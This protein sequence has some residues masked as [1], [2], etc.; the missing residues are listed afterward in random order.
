MPRFL[1]WFSILLVACE[2]PQQE[3]EAGHQDEDQFAMNIRTAEPNTPEQQQ[4]AFQLPDGFRIELFASEPDIGKPMNISFDA[5]GRLWVTQSQEYPFYDSTRAGADRI[6]ILE[7]TDRDGKADKFV[8]FA[9]SLNIPIGIVPV[10]DGAIAF[11]IPYVYHLEDLN[12]DDRVDRR[13]VLLRGFQYKD[14]HGMINN[15]FR[16]LDGW[17]HADHGFSNVSNVVGTD[18]RPPLTMTSGNTFRF[19]PDGTGVEFTTTGRVNPFGYAMDEFGY[20]YSVD[21]HSS[22]IYQLVR[23]ADYPHFGKKPAGIGFG[24]AMMPHNYGST[25]LAGLEYYTGNQFPEAFQQS[26]YLGDVVKSRVYRA[27][28]N[29]AGTT[30]V[31][32]WQQ[33]FIVSEDPWFRPVDIKLGPDGALY[34]ADFYNRIIGHYEVALDHPGRDRQRG[35]IW[36]VTYEPNTS[37][38]LST[39]WQTA[40]LPEL[41]AALSD[42]SLTVRMTVAD[43]IVDRYGE[44]AVMPIMELLDA[45][46]VTVEQFVHGIWIL[47]RLDKIDQDLIARCLAHDED[48]VG[49]HM[50]HILFEM[51]DLDNQWLDRLRSLAAH[52]NPHIRRAVLMILAKYP[53]YDQVEMLLDQ[54]SGVAQQDTHLAYTIKQ[55][56]RDHLRNQ[57]ILTLVNQKDWNIDHSRQLAE[58]MIGV[59]TAPSAGFLVKYLENFNQD[60]DRLVNYV[61]HIA[62]L[63]PESDLGTFRDRLRKLTSD[64]LDLQ[65]KVI[66][67]LQN[68]VA[69]RGSSTDYGK[70]WAI[71][72]ANTILDRP[73]APK[74]QGQELSETEEQ[75]IFA[76]EVAGTYKVSALQPQLLELLNSKTAD[77]RVRTPAASALLSISGGNFEN[78][79]EVATD[80][81]ETDQ[82]R[83]Q[84][85]LLL[86][87]Q[88]TEEAF[89]LAAGSL[90]GLSF[91]TQKKMVSSMCT[92]ESGISTVLQSAQSLDISPRIL[93]EPGIQSLLHANMNDLQR[94]NYQLITEDLTPFS[95]ETES[96]IKSRV[97]GFT[98]APKS[99]ETGSMVFKQHCASCHQ[100]SGAGGNVGPQLDGIGNRGLLALTEK[101]LDPN[102]SITKSFVNYSIAMKDGDVRQGLYRRQEGNLMVFADLAGQEFSIPL[103]EIE[104]QTALPFTIMPDNFSRTISEE[105]HYHLMFY[106]LEQ[107]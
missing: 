64:N 40:E 14:T 59:D 71:Q 83:E 23:G 43:Q 56:L 45:Q 21:C 102:R 60:P 65:Y 76:C 106:L 22:P 12:G 92:E 57:E 73:F 94:K 20:M 53:S 86:V 34:I 32:H 52:E 54:G 3:T 31:L 46:Q 44:Q 16:G 30:P 10:P 9:D 7:D 87:N 58:A 91:D 55:A 89:A 11:S 35:R 62:R 39:N 66:K 17:I 2:H 95:A 4:K 72:L 26:F 104:Q 105:D 19:R 63:L 49:I 51:E 37:Q 88:K 98:S 36:R 107:K 29:M 13:N 77:H 101:T 78:V 70:D 8:T 24:P 25:A 90:N 18:H 38:H 82:V 47:F 69:Q 42:P 27:T 81:Q 85:H 68:G 97:S 80:A 93:L 28:I 41:I 48:L 74:G 79:A 6:T 1:V 84:L 33:D 99:A 100:I 61:N 96:M 15:F 103:D 50:L 67:S 75:Q 5:R